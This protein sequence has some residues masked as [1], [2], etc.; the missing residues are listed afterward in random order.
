MEIYSDD[1]NDYH[2]SNEKTEMKK[3]NISF[4]FVKE[5]K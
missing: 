2:D 1:F 3:L 4:F 5:T